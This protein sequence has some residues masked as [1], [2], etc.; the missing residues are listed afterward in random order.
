MT[1]TIYC[2]GSNV[3]MLVGSTHVLHFSST[4]K[5]YTTVELMWSTIQIFTLLLSADLCFCSIWVCLKWFYKNRQHAVHMT[6][7]F[8]LLLKKDTIYPMKQLLCCNNVVT[9]P[10]KIITTL[11][12]PCHRAV[13][14]LWLLY[15]YNS[16]AQSYNAHYSF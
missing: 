14:I 4:L 16:K 3:V 15:G 13:T 9:I 1:L 11:L 12:P 5:P 10:Q 2:L 6:N 7:L 8:D